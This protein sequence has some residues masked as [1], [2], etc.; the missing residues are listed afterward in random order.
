MQQ[1][2]QRLL[3]QSPDDPELQRMARENADAL[4]TEQALVSLGGML[5]QLR[6]LLA[7][8]PSDKGLRTLLRQTT[9]ALSNLQPSTCARGLPQAEDGG[10]NEEATHGQPGNAARN[11]GAAAAASEVSDEVSSRCRSLNTIAME[12]L[13]LGRGAAALARLQE[14]FALVESSSVS[15]AAAPAASTDAT[16]NQL[17][18]AAA[19]PPWA[20]LREMTLRNLGLWAA[21]TGGQLAPT[22]PAPEPAP[23][24][25]AP[26]RRSSE[27]DRFVQPPWGSRAAGMLPL[28]QGG[29]AC[30]HPSAVLGRSLDAALAQHQPRARSTSVGRL[31][32]EAGRR[33]R[34]PGRSE[35]FVGLKGK[36][37]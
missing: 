5:Q 1:T 7:D 21:A 35:R 16:S 24:G 18:P 13:K 25:A 14:A 15:T 23:P 29:P 31:R 37:D 10:G 19:V 12:E 26:S 20:E 32:E 6:G 22:P 9:E 4:A 33:P 8:D 27:S 34:T 28:V 3:A 2:L 11:D 36:S 17:P 30:S